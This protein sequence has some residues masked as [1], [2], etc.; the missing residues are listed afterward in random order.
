MPRLRDE[1]YAARR[2]HI[3]DSARTCFSRRGFHAASM[4]DLQT[5]AGV[6]AGAIYVYFPGKADIVN[7]ITAANLQHLEDALTAVVYAEPV[8]AFHDALLQMVTV[9][10]RIAKGPTAGIAFDV[11]GEASRDPKVGK[12]VKKHFTAIR[13]LFSEVA[14]R[15]VITGELPRK[16]DT[17]GAGAILFVQTTLGY[18]TLR[19]TSRD[20]RPEAYTNGLISMLR[21]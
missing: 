5:E 2:Q 10:D 7:A 12:V 16:T 21:A 1:T 11:W 14:R 9:T 18:Y 4:M 20:V 17:D 13:S 6:S 19:L 3:L 8:P 15:A